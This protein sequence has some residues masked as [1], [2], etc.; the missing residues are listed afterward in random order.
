MMANRNKKANT[1]K[2]PLTQKCQGG[3]NMNTYTNSIIAI[4]AASP[5]R[6][7]VLIIRV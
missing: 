7:P 6:G 5:R 1:A 2:T 4:S 3:F